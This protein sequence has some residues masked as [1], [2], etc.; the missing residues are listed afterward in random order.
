MAT[1]EAK[2]L[3]LLPKMTTIEKKVYSILANQGISSVEGIASAGVVTKGRIPAALERM[4]ARG[5]V[6]EVDSS[7][8][9]EPVYAAVFPIERFVNVTSKLVSSLEGRQGELDVTADT[10]KNFTENVIKDVRSVTDEERRLQSERSVEDIQDLEKHLE[11]SFSGMVTSV[12]ADLQDL[13][14]VAQTSIEFLTGSSIRVQET[15]TNLRKDLEPLNEKFKQV[16]LASREEVEKHL[17]STVDGRIS[18]VLDFETNAIKAFDEILDAFKDSQDAFEEIIFTVLDSGIDDLEKVTRPINEQIEEAIGSL[19]AAIQDASSNFQT[20]IVRV[21]TEQKRPIINTI[22]SLRPRSTRIIADGNKQYNSILAEHLQNL[23]DILENHTALFSDSLTSSAKVFNDRIIDLVAQAT[24]DLATTREELNL[25]YEQLRQAIDLN[26][27][28]KQNVSKETANKTRDVLNEMM[29]QFITILNRYIAE[30]QLSLGD[31]I[32]VLENDFLSTIE[33]NGVSIQ[34]LVNY[35]NVSLTEPVRVLMNNLEELNKRI[36]KDESDFLVKFEESLKKDLLEISATFEN[37]TKKSEQDLEK[38]VDRLLKRFNK[39]ISDGHDI[40]S[41]RL[42]SSQKDLQV[43]FDNFSNLHDKELRATR[44]EISNLTKKLER[45]R[46]DSL[47][48]LSRRVNDNV[49]RSMDVLANEIDEIL[50][51]ID[52]TEN[53]SKEEIIKVVKQS[54]QDISNSFKG[55][56]GTVNQ[57]IRNSIDD[58]AETLKKDSLSINNRLVQFKKDQD[59]L[60]DE[61]KKPSFKLIGEISH[62]YKELYNKLIKNFERF[63]DSEFESFKRGR[64]RIAKS[65]ENILNRRGTRTSKEINSLKE[66]FERARE[67]YVKVTRERFE[68]IEKTINRDTAQLLDQERASRNTITT[69]ADKT[70][71]DLTNEVNT[72]AE[73]LRKGLW[74]GSEEIFGQASKEIDKQESQFNTLDGQLKDQLLQQTAD[75]DQTTKNQLD[76]IEQKVK[77][78]QDKQIGD[79]SAFRE[80]F[81]TTLNEDLNSKLDS[82]QKTQE[83]LQILS[84]KLTSS[85][86]EVI[87]Q[88][89][90]KAISELEAQV[91][92]IEGAI[93]NTVSNITAEAAEQTEGVAIIGEQ[94]VRGIEDRYTENLERIRQSLTDEVVERIGQ[95]AKKIEDYKGSLRN[96][97][98]NHLQAYGDALS[99]INTRLK[100]K[101]ADAEETILKASEI[102]ENRACRYLE[103]IDQEIIAQ[104]NKVGLSTD[105]YTKEIIEDFKRILRSVKREVS[106]FAKSQFELSDRSNAKIAEAFLKEVDDLEEVMVKQFTN[107]TKR[108]IDVMNRTIEISEVIKDHIKDITE[109]FEDLTN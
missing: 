83:N 90:N 95:E 79:I 108:T 105:Y 96:I 64:D 72:T 43:I 55:F 98:R 106:A 69:L 27:E 109:S 30:Y 54:Y 15:C 39:E 82:I 107:Y 41:N 34:N 52:T 38:D 80:Q 97:G 9:P 104:G 75:F 8:A 89:T 68:E 16:L 20:Q 87:D 71:I 99:A 22:E 31:T 13:S 28:N 61:T 53:F 5:L 81:T 2:D 4:I 63:F 85:I 23:S 74:D 62:D 18:N 65:F 21:L 14:K 29:E 102:I 24:D 35:I 40:L 37:D 94:A 67:N 47:N 91:S 46:G 19:R 103:D 49:D 7:D 45:W 70:I 12:E 92:G 58:I 59:K 57:L 42:S 73:N 88:E 100:E 33:K 11:A 76:S 25:Q 44:K 32:S 101:L 93:F 77:T 48:L 36:E 56:G 17:E 84:E 51:K 6:I 78:L 60:I 66:V 3:E 50:E 1:K 26:F 86:K 10:I